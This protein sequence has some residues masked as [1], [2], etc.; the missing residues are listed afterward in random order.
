MLKPAR[1]LG[2][3]AVCALCPPPV[4]PAFLFTGSPGITHHSGWF[5]E[6]GRSGTRLCGK[7]VWLLC[8]VSNAGGLSGDWGSKPAQQKDQRRRR[9][10]AHEAGA[11]AAAVGRGCCCIGTLGRPVLSIFLSAC[12]SSVS[13]SS[14]AGCTLEPPS[15]G[16]N[17][18]RPQN[19]HLQED[20]ERRRAESGVSDRGEKGSEHSRRK[21]ACVLVVESNERRCR[22]VARRSRLLAPSL[23]S[24]C[25]RCLQ[26]HTMSVVLPCPASPHL[27]RAGCGQAS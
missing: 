10:W 9:V 6:A 12:P 8:V 22:H 13:A 20:V 24:Q 3:G 5:E 19:R 14:E 11:A 23:C 4:L 17:T 16:T 1:A 2:R 27:L 15:S 26:L 18:R 7:C 25:T 21:Q